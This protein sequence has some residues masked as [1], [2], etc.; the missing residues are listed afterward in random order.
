MTLHRYWFDFDLQ[1]GEGPIGTAA[2]CGVTAYDRED[3]QHLL[4][5]RVF[6]GEL[7]PVERVVEDIDVSTLDP[8][9]VLPN[10]SAPNRRGVWFPMGYDR[11]Y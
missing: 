3:A 2:G 6:R 10:M 9:H 8:G 1:A 5:E 7:P 4:R 11:S